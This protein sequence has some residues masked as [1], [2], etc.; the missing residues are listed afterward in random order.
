MESQMP[1]RNK[2]IFHPPGGIAGRMK[3]GEGDMVRVMVMPP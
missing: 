3:D 1:G 2:R